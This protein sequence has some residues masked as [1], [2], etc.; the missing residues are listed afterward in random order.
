MLSVA[1]RTLEI[2]LTIGFISLTGAILLAWNSPATGYETS[3]YYSTPSGAW[4]CFSVSVISSI[5]ATVGSLY[6][7]KE[8]ENKLWIPALVL[9]TLCCVF[10]LSLY[11]IRNYTALGIAGDGGTHLG[12][13]KD[14][15]HGHLN[16]PML[17]YPV[18]HV[19]IAGIAWVL[20]VD[21][22]VPAKLI[23]PVFGAL[24]ILFIY[25]LARNLFRSTRAAALITLLAACTFFGLPFLVPNNLADLTLPLAVLIVFKS[26]SKSWK[27]K[28]LLLAVLAIFTLFHQLT[29][30][31]AFAALATALLAQ[32]IAKK[33]IPWFHAAVLVFV[34]TW[35][36]AWQWIHIHNT[37]ETI[38]PTSGT[39]TSLYGFSTEASHL[40]RISAQIQFASEH[41]YNVV[42]Y[43]LK[44]YGVLLA[45]LVLSLVAFPALL[46]SQSWKLLSLYGL[47]VA[48]GIMI[49]ILLFT[50]ISF[51]PFRLTSYLLITS[52]VFAGFFIHTCMKYMGRKLWITICIPVFLI[53]IAYASVAAV[54]PSPYMLND[55]LQNTQ[56]EFNGI[57]WLI[58]NK[59]SN[60]DLAGWHFPIHR[61]TDYFWGIQQ[62]DSIRLSTSSEYAIQL[63][64]HLGYD[65]HNIVGGNFKVRTYIVIT[66]LVRRHYIDVAPNLV[67]FGFAPEELAKLDADSSTD[68]IYDAGELDI[69]YV[70]GEQPCE[71]VS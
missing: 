41:G 48:T 30:L 71:S 54:Y 65:K 59:D 18:T 12:Y 13:I 43:F 39:E 21:P 66:E 69:W 10:V 67:E 31:V 11:I 34:V 60:T 49:I 35:F 57:Q 1:K 50:N 26:F 27:W 15:M 36:V 20:K 9:I 29:A 2:L 16:Y 4:A 42:E 28:V 8:K 32:L 52:V 19:I 68:K 62:S 47:F 24:Y 58:Q 6:F 70:Y 46:K 23:T 45:L 14:I 17:S 38:I 63:P 22:L 33:Q 37:A 7:L 5:I 25:L 44:R 53:S 51:G 40:N 61:Y 56:Q 55:N 3:I 64:A